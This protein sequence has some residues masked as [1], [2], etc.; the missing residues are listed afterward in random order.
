[1][2]VFEIIVLIGIGASSFALGCFVGYLVRNHDNEMNYTRKLMN[3]RRKVVS[4]Y[5]QRKKLNSL[6][7]LGY[8]NALKDIK[9]WL[10]MELEATK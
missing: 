9:A 1:M 4:D 8:S 7:M 6:F 5:N 10:D 3:I 2:D